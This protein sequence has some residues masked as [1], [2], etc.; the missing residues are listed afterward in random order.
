MNLKGEG[1][2]VY[3]LQIAQLH[4]KHS[5]MIIVLIDNEQCKYKH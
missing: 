2:T 5:R 1:K 4:I 3:C